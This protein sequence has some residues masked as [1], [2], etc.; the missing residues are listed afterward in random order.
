MGVLAALAAAAPLDSALAELRRQAER[1]LV[2]ERVFGRDWWDKDGVWTWEAPGD[3]ND[4]EG[5]AAVTLDEV[6]DAWPP[7]K[8]WKEQVVAAAQK[9]GLVVEELS[10]EGE[11]E[12]VVT[13]RKAMQSST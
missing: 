2:V 7:W 3:D 4:R 13:Q 5:D 6:V 8:L 9:R 12:E 1:E 10:Y 11:D